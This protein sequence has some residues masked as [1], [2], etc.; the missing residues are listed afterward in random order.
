MARRCNAAIGSPSVE[1]TLLASAAEGL[2]FMLVSDV[3]KGA[4]TAEKIG[5]PGGDEKAMA[6]S[7]LSRVSAYYM[8]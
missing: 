5:L 7:R 6:I 3:P 2:G 1:T 8:G 4:S